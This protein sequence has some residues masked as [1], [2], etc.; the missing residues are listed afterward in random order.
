MKLKTTI[1]SI[2]RGIDNRIKKCKPLFAHM[3]ILA[4][5]IPF[6]LLLTG[7]EKKLPVYT[8]EV[9]ITIPGMEDEVKLAFLSDLHIITLSDE[10]DESQ[11]ETVAARVG[12]SS[13]EGVSAKDQWPGWVDTLNLLEADYIL[14]G[15]DMV[16]VPT[17]SNIE[18]LK[19]EISRLNKPYMYIRADHDQSYS[20]YL[21]KDLNDEKTLSYQEAVCEVKDVYIKEFDDFIIV[22]WNLSTSLIT[23][24]GLNKIKT[25][26]ATGKPL[27]LLTHVPIQPLSD[28]SLSE[29][30]KEVYQDRALI[31]G[32]NP[33]L[34]FYF[35]T[36]DTPNGLATGE[37][38]DMIYAEDSPFVEVLCGHLHFSWDGQL[39]EKVHQHVF[40]A[41]FDRYMG[42]ITISGN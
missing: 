18:A 22:G 36:E 33:N 5:A 38:L 17:L 25:A 20:P 16:D 19:A 35:P 21:I 1:L 12:W 32:R 13:Y 6:A 29:K 7:C 24:E 41:A 37:L 34:T 39:T 9:H 27:I 42:L 4:L 28:E 11:K 8:E 40:S 30:S 14:F 31:W 26:A 23:P 15:G 2:L 3:C 10:I